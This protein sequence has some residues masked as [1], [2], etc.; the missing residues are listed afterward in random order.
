MRLTPIYNASCR[1]RIQKREQSSRLA[2]EAG[3]SHVEI[4]RSAAGIIASDREGL[5]ACAVSCGMKHDEQ[6]AGRFKNAGYYDC[7]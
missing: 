1:A 7:F 2:Q 5:S 4:I 3:Y 6:L